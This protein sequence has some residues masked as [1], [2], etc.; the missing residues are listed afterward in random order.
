MGVSR[1]CS[2]GRDQHNQC[3]MCHE[4]VFKIILYLLKKLYLYRYLPV[5]HGAETA[6]S[7]KIFFKKF[8]D[9]NRDS[10]QNVD[11]STY[12]IWHIENI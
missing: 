7:V 9:E 8:D 3:V 5:E 1:T 6:V 11:V 12:E 2:L 10:W 4:N